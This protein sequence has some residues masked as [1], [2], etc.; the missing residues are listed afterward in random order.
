[1]ENKI[2]PVSAERPVTLTLMNK[3]PNFDA[4]ISPFDFTPKVPSPLTFN[5]AHPRRVEY[6]RAFSTK[7][8][9]THEKVKLGH[10]RTQSYSGT[11]PNNQKVDLRKNP[12]NRSSSNIANTREYYAAPAYN[13][14]SLL[15]RKESMRNSQRDKNVVQ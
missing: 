6:K 2:F 8:S 3:D 11:Q 10:R 9:D 7:M 4:P 1:M 15:E 14:A 13:E 5:D 12:Y